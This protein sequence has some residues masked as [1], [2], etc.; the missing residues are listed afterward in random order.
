[1]NSKD[2]LKN[3]K[4]KDAKKYAEK[5]IEEYG[6]PDEVTQTMLKWNTLGSFGKGEMETFILD[7]SI[8][9]AFPGPHRDY[10]YT[11]M[12]IKVPS[13]KLDTL[14]HVTGS[15]IYDGLKETITARCG[16]LYANAAT[17]GFVRDLVEGKIPT[18]DA[19]AKKEY[20]K[21]IQKDP[22]PSFYD[23]RMNEG[24]EH[25][26]SCTSDLLKEY[27]PNI[28]YQAKGG[29]KSGK[30]TKS[31]IYSLKDK[32]ESK[33]EFRKSHVKDVKDGY[34]GTGH[35]PTP[36][37]FKKE[38]LMTTGSTPGKP[39]FSSKAD[40]TGPV[41]GY[42]PVMRFRKKL[43]KKD[44]D[45]LVMPGNKLQE[46]MEY[47]SRLF[48]YK[49]KLPEVGETIVYASNPAE[50]RMK[51]RLLINYRYR[52]DISIE[53]IM[54]GEAGKFFMDKRMKHMRNV[55]E[56]TDQ[57]MKQQMTRQQIGLEK[58][59]AND[60][61]VQIRKE[62]QKKTASLMKKQRAGGAQATVD[63]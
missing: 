49:V 27:S 37:K 8:P 5:L 41:A 30:L 29:R 20:A 28:A 63:K 3:W 53:R 16:S 17:M 12:K 57:Q 25:M 14:G 18:T 60:K 61:I 46:G 62:L 4:H 9:H 50:L 40:A 34:V 13:D 58:T 47:K 10:V 2:S 15:I 22:L 26:C 52:G 39:G 24:I 59:K 42:D 11:V 45:K 31:S 21:R 56:N 48:Q 6:Q 51:L 43:K 54:P 23:N 55:E 7:E 1:M 33:K 19:V 36:G 38:E 35:K 44:A 32:G